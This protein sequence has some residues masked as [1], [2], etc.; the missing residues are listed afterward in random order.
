V[1]L[2]DTELCPY[3]CYGTADSRGSVVGGAAVLEAARLVRTKVTRLAAHLLE[4]SAHDVEL[5][6]GECRV[7]GAPGRALSL[8]AIAREAYR[9]GN[10]PP[11]MDPGLE[12]RFTYQP[13]NW[14]HPYGIH[15]A[16]VEVAPEVGTVNVLGYWI[17]HDCGSLLNPMIVDGQITGGLAQGIGGALLEQLV[18]D[19]IGQPLCRT[20]M[21]YA[22]PT[23][24]T[25]PPL[26]IAHLE[27]PSP[28]TPGGM[29]GMAEGGT[30]AAPATI[31]NAVADALAGAGVDHG[32]ITFYPLTPARIFALL[33][34][35]GRPAAQ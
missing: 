23:A 16:A 29:K 22:L 13:E 17:A 15:V 4:A 18:Y 25:M 30:I 28:H 19:D 10:L 8:T 6:G 2:G 26:A 35:R 31:A 14:T 21:E 9:G 34:A 1:V 24:A 33:R 32:A 11:E 12:A 7:R 3:S 27:T 5:V 20:F